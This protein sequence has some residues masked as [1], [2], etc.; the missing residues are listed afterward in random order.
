MTRSKVA[1][2]LARKHFKTS[3][4]ARANAAGVRGW[5]WGCCVGGGGVAVVTGTP[6]ARP[7]LCHNGNLNRNNGNQLIYTKLS[8]SF[9]AAGL[10]G[11]RFRGRSAWQ[12]L[13]F[14]SQIFDCQ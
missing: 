12:S 4:T 2:N 8:S 5:G 13:I 1:H 3:T 6:P 10:C 11:G 7:H 9:S 14:I